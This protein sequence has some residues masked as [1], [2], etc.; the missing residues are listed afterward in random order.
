MLPIIIPFRSGSKQ[1]PY[2]VNVKA[3]VTNELNQDR[4]W[5]IAQIRSLDGQR[6]L[7]LIGILEEH[8]WQQIQV[9]LELVLGFSSYFS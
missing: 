2:T 5:D 4:F 1:A 6:I 7:G 3:N 8:Y 9:S